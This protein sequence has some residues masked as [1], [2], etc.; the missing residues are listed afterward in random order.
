MNIKSSPSTFEAE[1]DREKRIGCVQIFFKNSRDKSQTNAQ[2][3]ETRGI[4]EMGV[5][6]GI[7]NIK[8]QQM[9]ADKKEGK[10]GRKE[11]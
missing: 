3:V 6:C 8:E 4:N 2:K 5:K 11:R 10:L 7:L 1:K 9:S